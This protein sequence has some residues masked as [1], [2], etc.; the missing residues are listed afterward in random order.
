MRGV[1]KVILV[2]RLGGDPEVRYTQGGTAV[3]NFN[4]AT[5]ERFKTGEEWQ[6]RTEWH[7]V[8][9]WS[10][11]AEV[12]AQYLK[13]GSGVYIE[14]R[15]QTRKW[16]DRNGV[17]KYTTEIVGREMDFLDKREGGSSHG[18]DAPPPPGD[19]DFYPNG[20]DLDDDVPF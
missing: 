19:N 10:R 12:A 1:N 15:L 4:V 17:E 8:V 2:G 6:E 5:T 18:Q 7:R 14:G 3:C 9:L 11:Q 20:G 16:Q 13:K